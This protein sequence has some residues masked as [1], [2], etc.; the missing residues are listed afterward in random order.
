MIK[1]YTHINDEWSLASNQANVALRLLK[2][3]CTDELKY[4]LLY[5]KVKN[6]KNDNLEHGNYD[7]TDSIIKIEACKKNMFDFYSA[8]VLVFQ[9]MMEAYINHI[10][11]NLVK[12]TYKIKIIPDL[13]NVK[14]DTWVKLSKSKDFKLKWNVVLTS[15]NCETKNF[16]SYSSTIYKLR[17]TLTHPKNEN[18]EEI[19]NLRNNYLYKGY[20]NGWESIISLYNGLGFVGEDTWDNR[21]NLYKLKIV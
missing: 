20:K 6:I 8:S 15:L 10:I 1:F 19:K 3:G 11:N 12:E 21:V 17:I 14:I 7:Y 16:C 18:I 2:E 9:S 5:A 13:N 4:Q